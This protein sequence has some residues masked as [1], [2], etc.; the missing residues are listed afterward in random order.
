MSAVFGILGPKTMHIFGHWKFLNDF[1]G[2]FGLNNI[3]FI[4]FFLFFFCPPKYANFVHGR[5]TN[6][7]LIHWPTIDSLLSS[8]TIRH[9]Q[10]C[11]KTPQQSKAPDI[12]EVPAQ[13]TFYSGFPTVRVC[14]QCHPLQPAL[15]T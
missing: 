11:K 1:W 4:F 6:D 3:F 15:I 10:S 5:S 12:N 8:N 13:T 7:F 2:H 14:N 9:K